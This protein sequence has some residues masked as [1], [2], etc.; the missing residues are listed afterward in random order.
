MDIVE[1]ITRRQ[2]RKFVEFPDML[3]AKCPQYVPALHK[4]QMDTL[5]KDAALEYCITKKWMAVDKKGNVYGRICAIINPRYN[6]RYG[7]KYCRFGWF[8]VIEDYDLAK[9]LID[10]AQRWAKAQGMTQ[11]HGPLFY[12]TLGKQGMLVEGFEN[13]PQANTLYNFPYYP[14]FL[15][16]MGF[17][18]ECDWLQYK[19]NA[20]DATDRIKALGKRLKERYQLESRNVEEIKNDPKMVQQFLQAYSDIFSR[21]VYNFIPFT[22]AEMD[23]EARGV[24]G[25]L[26]NDY[27]SILYDKD[28][29]LAGFGIVFPSLSRAL[30]KAK[31]RL[32]PLGWYYILKDLKRNDN[33]VADMMLIGGAE[34]WEGKGISA[35][36]HCDLAEKYTR[37]KVK[38]NIS[39]PQIETNSAVNVWSTYNNELYMRRRCYIK[40]ID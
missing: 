23:Q 28:G 29:E 6:E 16:R 39:N 27:C 24:L 14:E 4:D 2:L 33:P 11:I 13:V 34:K 32:F 26:R 36:V 15:E 22:Q 1:V 8:D 12:N 38:Y 40:D 17:V 7:K 19:V 35:V 31:G 21:S 3:Y 30:Q 10:T 20:V 9:E 37:L 18:K 5:T 25:M